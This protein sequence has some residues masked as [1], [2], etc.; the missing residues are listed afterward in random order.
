MPG[1]I[2]TEKDY[3]ETHVV[4]VLDEL[5]QIFAL[6]LRDNFSE[7]AFIPTKKGNEQ[8]VKMWRMCVHGAWLLQGAI[9]DHW[10]SGRGE[11]VVDGWL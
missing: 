8:L 3:L 11:N 1:L 9:W 2:E 6:Q 7:S 4:Q 5:R 10:V